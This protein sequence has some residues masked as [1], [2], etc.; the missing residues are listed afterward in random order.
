VLSTLDQ[1]SYSTP[2]PV[3]TGM[4]DSIQSSTLVWENLSQYITSYPGQ[5]SQAIPLWVSAVSKGWTVKAGVVREWV[6]G[7]T[8]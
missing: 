3:S 4:G 7:K 5:L 8:V 6:A 1:Q 2:G